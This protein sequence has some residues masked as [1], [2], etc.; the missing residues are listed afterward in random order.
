MKMIDTKLPPPKPVKENTKI[1][2]SY[3]ERDRYPYGTI[4]TLEKE[5]ISRLGLDLKGLNV[6]DTFTIVATAD[7]IEVRSRESLGSD[8][9]S[10]SDSKTV[11]LQIKKLGLSPDPIANAFKQ[12]KNGVAKPR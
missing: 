2:L 7:V 10:E 4:I 8:G 1:G 9:I 12:G 6:G 3:P 11:E 5:L